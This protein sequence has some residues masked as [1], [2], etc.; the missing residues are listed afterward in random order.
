[1]SFVS[2]CLVSLHFGQIDLVIIILK[3]IQ[4][5][6]Q[7]LRLLR[8]APGAA[9]QP[10]DPISQDRT[11]VIYGENW[12]ILVFLHLALPANSRSI[13]GISLMRSMW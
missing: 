11:G 3:N 13:T 1:M 7:H 9:N 2:S 12:I 6:L 5:V 10:C 4:M 8:E